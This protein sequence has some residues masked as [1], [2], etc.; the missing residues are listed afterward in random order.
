MFYHL[1]FPLKKYFSGFNL[2]QYI[3]FRA[4]MAAI[5][6][7]LISF[8][9]GPFVLKMLRKYQIGELIRTDGPQTHQEKK[10]TPTMGGILI[11]FSVI[12]PVLLWANL[13]N[14]YINLILLSTIWMGIF[15]FIDDYLKVVKKMK[16]GLIAR[17]KLM[18]QIALGAVVGCYLYFSPEFANINSI[19]SVPFLK[20][21]MLNLGW[22]YIPFIIFFITG[23]SNAVNLTDGLDGL[24]AGLMG[25]VALAFAVIAYITGRVDFSDYLNTI[26]LPG[27]GE[28]TVFCM[29]TGGAMLG[30]LWFNSKPAQVFMGDTGSLAMGSALATLAILL[31]KEI[32]FLI[33][34]ALFIVEALSVMLQVGYFKWTKRRTG[35]GERLFKMAPLHHH[36]EMQ[37]LSE[38]KIVIRFWIIG[39]LLALFSLSTFK[40]L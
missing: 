6:A 34:G 32:L 14:T 35:T 19:T 29:A 23:I 9:I 39:I 13:T 21:V 1:F 36:Y 27:S 12:L 5:T 3:T 10:G 26:Y 20:N 2:F 38:T 18:G 33:L 11:L 31:K 37:G 22:L 30:F 17:Y 40:I 24:A 7:L 16:K 8:I 28:L 15:G 4:V 25:I